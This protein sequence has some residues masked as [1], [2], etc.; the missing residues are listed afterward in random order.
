[1]HGE[2]HAAEVDVDVGVLFQEDPKPV[3]A[4]SGMRLEGELERLLGRRC[5]VVTMNTAPVDLAIRV[6]RAE[7]LL[8]DR[9][10]SARIRFEVRTRNEFFD[11]EPHR[12]RYRR[13]ESKA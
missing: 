12:K 2:G 10:R 6:M 13:T 9:D 7:V 5:R 4:S 1:M 11:P 8:L 3:R